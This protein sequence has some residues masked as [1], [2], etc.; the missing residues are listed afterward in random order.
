[1]SPRQ[2][3]TALSGHTRVQFDLIDHRRDV[4]LLEQRVQVARRSC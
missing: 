1:M 2:Y 3:S 4:G